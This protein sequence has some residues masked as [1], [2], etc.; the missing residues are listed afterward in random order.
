MGIRDC[1]A[2]VS[3]N[4]RRHTHW[5]RAGSGKRRP[6][7]VRR[8]T[9][10]RARE[11]EDLPVAR[12]RPF[13]RGD[14][15]DL[16]GGSA[17]ISGG[18]A[19]AAQRVG[20][21]GLPSPSRLRPVPGSQDH[22]LAKESLRDQQVRSRGSTGHRVRLPPPGPEP[23]T[24]E[25]HRG[26]LEGPRQRRRPPGD[27]RRTAR[28]P[29][30]GSWPTPASTRSRPA[31]SPTTTTSWTPA[32]WSARS[33]PGTAPPSTA[34]AARRLLRDGAR[35]PGRGAAGD[36]QVVR[37]QLPLP[38]PRARPRHRLHRRLRPSRSPS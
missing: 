14:P 2:A 8:V 9:G 6:V 34:D 33:P 4:D 32:S 23:G 17:Y 11:S 21:P 18:H 29:T 36:D 1:P 25:G 27:R 15:G 35:H 20:P 26:L 28:A 7:G 38:G 3:G 13:V 16:E 30:G 5:A 37:H 31:T 22:E 10:R 24:E 19:R 12:A